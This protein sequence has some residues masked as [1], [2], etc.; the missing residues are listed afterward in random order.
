MSH[1][2]IPP[3]QRNRRILNQEVMRRA[4]RRNELIR[5][6]S[7]DEPNRPDPLL[8]SCAEPADLSTGEKEGLVSSP[9]LE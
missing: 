8:L 1:R 6:T 3:A 5:L 7:E 9:T 4:H 2:A